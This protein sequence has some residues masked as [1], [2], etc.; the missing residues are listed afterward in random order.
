MIFNRSASASSGSPE[1]NK[2]K[3]PA[4]F[5][6]GLFDLFD[7]SRFMIGAGD[8]T[9]PD[10][11]RRALCGG[12]EAANEDALHREE[13]HERRDRDQQRPRQRDRWTSAR[14]LSLQRGKCGHDRANIRAAR[15]GQSKKQV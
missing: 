12:A 8:A 7:S 9:V 3:S 14:V 1:S 4:I 13:E 2:S 10:D 11:D 5:D 6:A 15:K